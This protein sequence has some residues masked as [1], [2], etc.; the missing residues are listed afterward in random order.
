[1]R[2]YLTEHRHGVPG[3]VNALGKDVLA[4]A[5]D[6]LR[7]Q[8]RAALY[9]A[10]AEAPGLRVVEHVQDGAGRPG[11]GIAWPS[12]NGLK[13]IVLVFDAE[14]YVYLGMASSGVMDLAIVN[15]VGQTS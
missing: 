2:A 1:M 10:A 12:T 9:E 14:T 4:L 11:I 8:S 3:D 7:P 5:E 13:E 15:E 6:Y